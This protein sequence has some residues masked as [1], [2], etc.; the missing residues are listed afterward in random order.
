MHFS[1]K[2]ILA[3]ITPHI[4]RQVQKEKKNSSMIKGIQTKLGGMKETKESKTF[5]AYHKNNLYDDNAQN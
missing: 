2:I 3:R 1:W 5:W 4:E